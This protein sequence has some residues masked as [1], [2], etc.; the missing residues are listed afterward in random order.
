MYASVIL[1]GGGSTNQVILEKNSNMENIASSLTLKFL[2][3]TSKKIYF[4]V[5][6]GP[7]K[8]FKFIFWQTKLSFEK[9]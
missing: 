3:L 8:V 4:V 6:F 9:K 7:R 2:Y 5:H 1:G